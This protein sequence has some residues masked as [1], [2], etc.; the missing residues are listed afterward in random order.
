[1]R[2][3]RKIR[4]TESDLHRIV[5]NAVMMALNE[6]QISIGDY[7]NMKSYK[8]DDDYMDEL[9]ASERDWKKEPSIGMNYHYWTPEDMERIERKSSRYE[10]AKETFDKKQKAKRRAC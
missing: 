3:I 4:L 2:K 5:S 8:D 1:M 10:K 7:G 6:T 9:L